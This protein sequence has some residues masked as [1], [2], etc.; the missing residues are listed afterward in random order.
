MPWLL[1]ILVALVRTMLAILVKFSS[2]W[3]CHLSKVNVP[4]I[5]YTWTRDFAIR[6]LKPGA[7]KQ[8][9]T[10]CFDVYPK[11][12]HIYMTYTDHIYSTSSHRHACAV[13]I[14]WAWLQS[15]CSHAH[16]IVTAHAL[17]VHDHS[18]VREARQKIS[19]G[20][21]YSCVAI[22]FLTLFYLYLYRLCACFVFPNESFDHRC[23][24]FRYCGV[25]IHIQ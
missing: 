9:E 4:Q 14:Q 16:Q 15:D 20:W 11:S 7:Y 5:Q 24:D 19:F 23:F 2:L 6:K 1:Q 17:L 12:N 22:Y 25:H 10:L 13:T 21:F 8:L 3:P 18:I